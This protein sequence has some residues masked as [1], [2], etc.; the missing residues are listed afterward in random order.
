[1]AFT[2]KH[3]KLI[4]ELSKI[5]NIN[6]DFKWK[7]VEIERLLQNIKDNLTQLNNRYKHLAIR[8]VE[9]DKKEKKNIENFNEIKNEIEFFAKEKSKSFPY[10]AAVISDYLLLKDNKVASFLETKKHPAYTT[11]NSIRIITNEKKI[12]TEQLLSARYRIKEYEALFP[13]I[14]ECVDEDIDVILDNL[15][16]DI[17]SIT[18]EDDPVKQFISPNEYESLSSTERNQK[19]LDRFL[20]SRN[21]NSYQIGKDYER[22][23]GYTY[24]NRGYD[25]TYYGIAEGVEDLGRDLICKSKSNVEIVQCKYWSSQKT[26][27]EKHI[28]QLFGTTV[29]YCLDFLNSENI[30]YNH[31]LFPELLKQNNIKGVFYTSTKLS[32]TAKKFADALNIEYHENET[33]KQYPIIKCH[34]NKQSGEKIYHLPFDQ[35]YDRTILE[36]KYGE[37]YACNVEEAET[38]GFRR[39]WKWMGNS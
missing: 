9:I 22:Y 3:K 1:M 18:T 24:E 35:M 16:D 2:I 14:S 33:L 17:K 12:L 6:L 25:V 27:H 32:D 5:D 20:A 30:K 31:S 7:K 38:R 39:A 34:I 23:I 26:I 19:A 37:F 13:S 36:E 29:K 11:A 21:K 4:E 8:E 10:I 28:N 15:N